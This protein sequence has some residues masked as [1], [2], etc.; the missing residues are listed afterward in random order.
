MVFANRVF[1][2]K[3]T[4]EGRQ[5]ASAKHCSPQSLARWD[6]I[7]AGTLTL[8]ATEAADMPLLRICLL[9]FIADFANWDNS[10]VPAY[11]ETS[12][13]LTQAAHEALGGV[14][15]TRPLV[16]DPFAGG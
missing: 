16:V 1:P 14:P 11:L 15:G 2:K 10:T 3:I 7:A 13:S 5:L 8:D 4:A 6:A 12:R 9:D